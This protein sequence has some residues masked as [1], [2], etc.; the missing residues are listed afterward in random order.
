MPARFGDG[1]PG[2]DKLDLAAGSLLALPEWRGQEGL[3]RRITL[4]PG[5]ITVS[6]K[7]LARAE[8]T[9]ERAE[10]RR[11][12]DA[13]EEARYFVEHDGEFREPGEPG[14]VIT[15]WS[16]RS[17]ARL[18]HATG[19][20][21]YT[22]MIVSGEAPVMT[23]LTYP[24]R[25]LEV[26]PTGAAAKKHLETLYVRFERA[27]G[28]PFC[29]LWKEEFQRRGA[30]HFH[31]WH[32]RPPGLAGTIR[33]M[34]Y[35]DKLA[36][37]KA[38]KEAGVKGIRKP[39]WRDAAGDGL[40]YE[41]WISVVWADIVDHPNP[42]EKAKHLLHGAQVSEVE[43]GYVNTPARLAA[44]FAKHGAFM[45]KDYQ[46]KVPAAWR[47][48]GKGPGRF[49]GYKAL[50]RTVRTVDV[51]P[52]DA[53]RAARLLRRLAS[54]ERYW[55][56]TYVNAEGQV[57]GTYRWKKAVR[58]VRVRRTNR[59]EGGA[60]GRMLRS[61]N[62]AVIGL[63]GSQYLEPLG[64]HYRKVM[65]PVSRFNSGSGFLCLDDAPTVL[66][67]LARALDIWREY[68]PDTSQQESA[69]QAARVRRAREL[70][71]TAKRA[72][73]DQVDAL[74]ALTELDHDR[75]SA[76]AKI[77]QAVLQRDAQELAAEERGRQAEKRQ[78]GLQVGPSD[79]AADFRDRRQAA[80]AARAE[81][82][83]A[84][85]VRFRGGA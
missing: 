23:T 44:Y 5:C 49:W 58:Q 65:R 73:T 31:L 81:D 14:A 51:S 62:A 79:P 84:S 18:F 6:R 10:A 17:R 21:D 22:P 24:D 57:V 11:H 85:L 50:T 16:R 56:P 42:K 83:A 80:T 47:E 34:E 1:F 29:G 59:Q 20:I 55:D 78:T 41:E 35:E 12:M 7:D 8:R 27:W 3:R 19:E 39:Y 75:H 52:T 74:R 82:V 36:V 68:N 32:P 64:A 66:V 28:C 4:G 13:Q 69:R 30:V 53:D 60:G 70:P 45:A 26:A 46:N 61:H 48:P 43:E 67:N 33:R 37:W 77:R 25:W 72:R 40:P 71:L 9:A 76:P 2:L 63:A 38:A 15:G 54:R